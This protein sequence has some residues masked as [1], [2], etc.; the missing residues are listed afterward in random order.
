VLDADVESVEGRRL[1]LR[2]TAKSDTGELLATA[3]GLFVE[4][5]A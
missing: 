4:S 2:A 1:E 3:T 5:R